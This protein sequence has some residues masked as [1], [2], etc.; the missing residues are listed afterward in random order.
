MCGIPTSAQ[1]VC[2]AA[3]GRLGLQA[4]PTAQTEPGAGRAE[5]MAPNLSV[6]EI[7]D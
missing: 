6:V 5:Q 1:T 3:P 7:Q 4:E 2:S